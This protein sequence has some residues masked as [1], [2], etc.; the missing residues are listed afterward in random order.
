MF[1]S[2]MVTPKDTRTMNL[3][4]QEAIFRERSGHISP[5]EAIFSCIM[6]SLKLLMFH[7]IA[8]GFLNFDFKGIWNMASLSLK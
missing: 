8:K 7:Q 4:K 2:V 5:K 3:H 1:N 6:V